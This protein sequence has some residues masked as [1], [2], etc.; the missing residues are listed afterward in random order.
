MSPE[1]IQ[2]SVSNFIEIFGEDDTV[3]FIH[4]AETILAE[5]RAPEKPAPKPDP[6][7]EQ[8]LKPKTRNPRRQRDRSP[9]ELPAELLALIRA[10]AALGMDAVHI[11]GKHGLYATHGLYL[12][13]VEMLIGETKTTRSSV[14]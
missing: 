12:S 2:E 14:T 4:L 1:H 6:A 9:K 10:D 7:F 5:R 11:S 13:D 8:S 3:R